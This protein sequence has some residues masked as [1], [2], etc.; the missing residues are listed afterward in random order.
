MQIIYKPISYIFKWNPSCKALLLT[1]ITVY[2]TV[3]FLDQP[4]YFIVTVLTG[5]LSRDLPNF[6]TQPGN[7][8]GILL[9]YR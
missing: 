5:I 6:V 9:V 1:V 4:L 2:K 3:M 8:L 7:T